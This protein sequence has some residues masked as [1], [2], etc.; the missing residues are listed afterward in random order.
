M[1]LAILTAVLAAIAAAEGGGGPVAGLSW[2]LAAIASATLVA[3]LT[4]FVAAHRLALRWPAANDQ[5]AEYY[6]VAGKWQSAIICL[7][8]T[9]VGVI[10]VVGQWPRIVRANWRLEG[11]PL[12]DELAIL[13]PV[14]APLLLIWSSMY[15]MERKSLVS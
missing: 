9:G 7:W 6:A 11:W 4:A 3:P 15:S 2:R 5:Q 10:L 12:V 1:Q 14:I 13:L 8:L